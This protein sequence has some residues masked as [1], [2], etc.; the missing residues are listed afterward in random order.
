MV[1]GKITFDMSDPDDRKAHLRC[2]KSLDM[3]LVLWTFMRQTR[4]EFENN[5]M[6][7]EDFYSGVEQT[8]EKFNEL[9][10]EYSINIDELVD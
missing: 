4:K 3:A 9:L 7:S 1:K 8:F 5:T 2:V 6:S 10:E